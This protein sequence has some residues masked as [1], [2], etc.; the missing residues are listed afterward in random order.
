MVRRF[1]VEIPNNYHC[2][3]EAF[4]VLNNTGWRKDAWK[5]PPLRRHD[6]CMALVGRRVSDMRRKP[7]EG[8]E[9]CE[10]EALMPC[11]PDRDAGGNLSSADSKLE[12]DRV[13]DRRQNR[14]RPT[15]PA[16]P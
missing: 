10:S 13:F 11:G 3:G 1:D 2:I 16:S 5:E 7:M 15:L 6:Y 14:R 4:L 12:R 8:R 9:S